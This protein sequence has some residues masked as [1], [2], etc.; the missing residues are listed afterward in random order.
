VLDAAVNAPLQEIRMSTVKEQIGR[1]VDVLADELEQL[2]HRIHAHPELGYQE[3][4]AAAWLAD[5]LAGQGFTVERGLAGVETAFR[6]TIG[7]GQGPTIAI[8]CEY[9]ALPSIGR[10]RLRADE[11]QRRAARGFPG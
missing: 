5:F 2:S 10:K 8:M 3:V 4:K 1:A 6:A 11:A 9:D 7:A